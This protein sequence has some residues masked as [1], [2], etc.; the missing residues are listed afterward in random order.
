[1]SSGPSCSTLDYESRMTGKV[2]MRWNILWGIL[3]WCFYALGAQRGVR[4][5]SIIHGYHSPD[6][7]AWP[8]LALAGLGLHTSLV[9]VLYVLWFAAK[10]VPLPIPHGVASGSLRDDRVAVSAGGM[11]LGKDGETRM[12]CANP[13]MIRSCQSDCRRGE[14]W[15]RKLRQVVPGVRPSPPYPQA[16]HARTLHVPSGASCFGRS[17]RLSWHLPLCWP[18]CAPFPRGAPPS[19][20]SAK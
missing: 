6:F 9:V 7:S 14:L 1:M 16:R 12:V 5:A 18:L 2:T 20:S 11:S 19:G 17:G 13:V 8:M 10:A 4:I 15:T 3:F